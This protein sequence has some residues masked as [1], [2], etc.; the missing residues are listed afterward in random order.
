MDWMARPRPTSLHLAVAAAL[1]VAFASCATRPSGPPTRESIAASISHLGEVEL[2]VCGQ[3]ALQ[4][5]EHLR[6]AMCFSLLADAFPDGERWREATLGAAHAWELEGDWE[7]ALQR[8][9]AAH[10]SDADDDLSLV[11]K[12][13]SALYEL[14]RYEE[15]LA[16][17]EPLLDRADLSLTDRIRTRTWVGVCRLEMGDWQEAEMDFRRAVFLYQREKETERVD[18]YF[19][20][21]AQFFLGEVYRLHYEA[22]AIEQTDDVE[23]LSETFEEKAQLLLSAQG[24]YVRAVRF[25]HPHWATAAGQRIGG[26]YER[27]HDEMLEAPIPSSL[28]PAQR[29]L[30]REELRAKVRILV[31]KAIAAYERTLTVAERLG[32]DTAFVEETRRSLR[33]MEELL[34]EGEGSGAPDPADEAGSPSSRGSVISVDGE[35]APSGGS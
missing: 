4:A 34:L 26:L 35:A 7:R 8:Y 22:I 1:V 14:D 3:A 13:T 5:R 21:Q 31:R 24:H 17:L 27:L 9:R 6:A 10:D 12:I 11:W 20:A 30:Y 29:E 16:H 19:P 23:R 28:T 18:V 2:W 25:G 32:L 15:A 33:R